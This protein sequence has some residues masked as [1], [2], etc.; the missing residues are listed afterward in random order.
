MRASANNIWV[1]AICSTFKELASASTKLGRMPSAQQLGSWH[2]MLGCLTFSH[3]HQQKT[4]E[5]VFKSCTQISNLSD[6]KEIV[7]PCAHWWLWDSA[8]ST[9]LINVSSWYTCEKDLLSSQQVQPL[10]LCLSCLSSGVSLSA[11]IFHH[12]IEH[13]REMQNQDLNL[14]YLLIL[15][16]IMP[17]T[18][19]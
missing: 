3:P 15:L 14:F 19:C 2:M 7:H 1:A 5:A 6:L 17:Q 18:E 4:A 12:L 10:H 8:H 16:L 9:S 11:L 13:P